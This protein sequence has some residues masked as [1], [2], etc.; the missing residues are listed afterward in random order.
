MRLMKS[1]IFLL[2]LGWNAHAVNY[3]P[4]TQT[5]SEGSTEFSLDAS[6]FQTLLHANFDGEVL[7][8]EENENF[9]KIESNLLM[10][11]GFTDNLQLSGG[12]KFRSLT[13]TI[14]LNDEVDTLTNSGVD[15]YMLQFKYSFPSADNLQYSLEGNYRQTTYTNGNVTSGATADSLVLGDSGQDVSVGFGMSYLTTDQNFFSGKILYRNP[16]KNLSSEIVALGEYAIVWSA[17]AIYGGIEAVTS[18]GQDAYSQDPENK[19][20]IAT[21]NTYLYNSVNR[22]WQAPYVGVVM[23]IGNNW[24]IE[25]RAK[26]FI[27]G[28]STDL[29]IEHFVAISR[30]NGGFTEYQ[31]INGSFKEY[32]IE[33]NVYKIGK[34]NST[35]MINSGVSGGLHEG[36]KVDFYHFDYLGGNE[37]IATGYV[38]KAGADKSM[39]RVSKRFSK[40]KIKE[41]TVARAGLLSD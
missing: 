19:P 27:T 40:R 4:Y 5:L 28:S 15:S 38:L 8:L 32:T 22:S 41:G 18:L 39:V 33:A 10:S 21:R 30:R 20:Q 12:V 7:E 9:I 36:M 35:V 1:L 37:L 2:I 14:T 34:N 31:K 29:G 16:S 11:Y 3:L 6:Y 17:L 13:S 25:Y 24:K 26:N 23:G